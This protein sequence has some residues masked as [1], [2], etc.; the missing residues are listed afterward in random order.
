MF[1]QSLIDPCELISDLFNESLIIKSSVIFS[2]LKG[3]I[4][5]TPTTA[6]TNQNRTIILS[7]EGTLF[8]T[9]IG[10]YPFPFAFIPLGFT[11]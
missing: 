11:S 4:S 1:L 5:V 6:I 8:A 7:I 3:E 9:S 10:N 2:S